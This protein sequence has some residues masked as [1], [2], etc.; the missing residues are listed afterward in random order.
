MNLPFLKMARTSPFVT[1]EAYG[2]RETT[3]GR[4]IVVHQPPLPQDGTCGWRDEAL[5]MTSASRV[6]ALSCNA[7]L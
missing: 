2:R 5:Y 4:D 1:V 6:L 7:A 3:L